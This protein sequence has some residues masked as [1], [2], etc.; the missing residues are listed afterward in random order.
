MLTGADVEFIGEIDE[1]R[2]PAFSVRRAACCFRSIG[3]S[4]SGW[5]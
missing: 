5:S 3:R 4:R 2:K 1:R